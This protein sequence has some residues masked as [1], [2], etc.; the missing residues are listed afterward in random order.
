MSIRI[1]LLV[2]PRMTSRELSTVVYRRC[3]TENSYM[4]NQY[5]IVSVWYVHSTT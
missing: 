3:C 1:S 2:K 5:F 4:L